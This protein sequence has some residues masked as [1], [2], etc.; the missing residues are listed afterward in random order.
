MIGEEAGG[1]GGGGGDVGKG[2]PFHVTGRGR[3][4]PFAAAPAVNGGGGWEEEEL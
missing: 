3:G 1:G 4:C 2:G